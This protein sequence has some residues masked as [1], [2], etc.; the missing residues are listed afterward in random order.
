MIDPQRPNAGKPA[1]RSGLLAPARRPEPRVRSGGVAGASP[2]HRLAF[3][4]RAG[5]LLISEFRRD[6][7]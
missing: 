5:R 2:K 4:F 6:K 3:Q 1:E 7:G